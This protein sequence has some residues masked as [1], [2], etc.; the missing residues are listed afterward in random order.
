LPSG[1]IGRRFKSGHADPAHGPLAIFAGGLFHAVQ[2]VQQQGLPWMSEP[3]DWRDLS[4][5]FVQVPASKSVKN[6]IHLDV[7]PAGCDRDTEVARLNVMCI[8]TQRRNQP[9]AG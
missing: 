4:I 6:R 7:S 1:R 2:A 5:V 3:G 8:T 9:Y